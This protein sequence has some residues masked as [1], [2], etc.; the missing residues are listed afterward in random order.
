M[1]KQYRHVCQY[2]PRNAALNHTALNSPPKLNLKCKGSY[3]GSTWFK[4]IKM[5]NFVTKV[6]KCLSCNSKRIVCP[7][8]FARYQMFCCHSKRNSRSVP[9]LWYY[10]QTKTQSIMAIQANPFLPAVPCRSQKAYI[11]RANQ[12]FLNKHFEIIIFSKLDHFSIF[13]PVETK[14]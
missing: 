1:D 5:S 10:Y 7:R 8:E 3:F 14:M 9:L 4:I 6:P 12:S 13:N 2:K 11:P